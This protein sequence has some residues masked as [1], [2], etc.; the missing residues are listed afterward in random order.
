MN[1]LGFASKVCIMTQ[2]EQSCMLL[3]TGMIWGKYSGERWC[4]H[5]QKTLLTYHTHVHL[6]IEESDLSSQ[7]QEDL[8]NLSVS[9]S[10]QTSILSGCQVQC[11]LKTRLSTQSGVQYNHKT[12]VCSIK[13]QLKNFPKATKNIIQPKLKRKNLEQQQAYKRDFPLKVAAELGCY[14]NFQ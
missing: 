10:Y 6:F 13:V 4:G 12:A 1:S 7:W 8:Q 14:Q 3:A 5:R 2:K 9:S 11:F